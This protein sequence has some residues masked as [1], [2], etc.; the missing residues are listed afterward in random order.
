MSI[1]IHL[2]KWADSRQQ[3]RPFYMA[4]LDSDEQMTFVNA[5]FIQT[6]RCAKVAVG[7]AEFSGLTHQADQERVK[8]A[9]GNCREQQAAV[10]VAARVKNS[11]YQ[12]IQ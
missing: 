2:D 5:P 11:P 12:W 4:V 9:I 10:T 8:K 6:F 3:H 1:P 7:K